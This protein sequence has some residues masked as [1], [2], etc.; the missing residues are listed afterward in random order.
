[1]LSETLRGGNVPLPGMCG[2]LQ[3]LVGAE[4]NT[5]AL[6]VFTIGYVR[7]AS[8]PCQYSRVSTIVLSHIGRGGMIG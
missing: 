3:Y 6:T 5:P 8:R 1:M 4:D 2:L 7:T